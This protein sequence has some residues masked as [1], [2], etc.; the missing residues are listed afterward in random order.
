M[1][2]KIRKN[3]IRYITKEPRKSYEN[4][5]EGMIDSKRVRG[6]VASFSKTNIV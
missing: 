2:C 3:E 5:E 6:K 1:P 4:S